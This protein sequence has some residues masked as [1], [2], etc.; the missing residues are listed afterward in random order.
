MLQGRAR[1]RATLGWLFHCFILCKIKMLKY[2]ILIKGGSAPE[3]FA[4]L[5]PL[6][7]QMTIWDHWF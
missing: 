7:S 3:P 4:K 2:N 6:L 1:E 5:S